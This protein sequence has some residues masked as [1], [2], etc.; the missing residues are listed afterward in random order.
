MQADRIQFA[1]CGIAFELKARSFAKTGPARCNGEQLAVFES[2]LLRLLQGQPIDRALEFFNERYAE[3][4]SD[5]TQIRASLRTRSGARNHW[6]V[7]DG[8]ISFT[9]PISLS[10]SSWKRG[11]G[12]T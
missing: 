7:W 2:S 3:L 11:F 5:L 10:N 12:A 6:S 8:V 4:F 9:N 1:L